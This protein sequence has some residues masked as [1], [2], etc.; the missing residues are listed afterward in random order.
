MRTVGKVF[1]EN[2]KKPS[3]KEKPNG[4]EKRPEGQQDGNKTTEGGS[5]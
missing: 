5:D 2:K 4:K 3:Q 1:T